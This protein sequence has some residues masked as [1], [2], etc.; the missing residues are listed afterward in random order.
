MQRQNDLYEFDASLVYR[1]TQALL[2]RLQENPAGADSDLGST[3]HKPCDSWQGALPPARDWERSLE[4][5]AQDSQD[6]SLPDVLRKDRSLYVIVIPVTQGKDGSCV[7]PSQ[8]LQ[9]HEKLAD[10]Q[11]R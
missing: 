3:A 7:A 1:R 5:S 4:S 11:P 9:T 6:A 8:E 2:H 10:P